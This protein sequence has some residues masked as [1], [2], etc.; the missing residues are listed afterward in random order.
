MVLNFFNDIKSNVKRESIQHRIVHKDGSVRWL[1]NS[2]SVRKDDNG[3]ISRMDGFIIDITEGRLAE[4][5]LKIYATT[6]VMT[7]LLNRRAGFIILENKLNYCRKNRISLSISFIDLNNLKKVND[8]FGHTE[9][10]RMIIKTAQ[11]IKQNIRDS[12]VAC[13]IGGDEFLLILPDCNIEAAEKIM[14]RVNSTL[15]DYNLKKLKEYK[16]SLSYGLEEYNEINN[17]AAEELVNK[18][19][20]RM[21]MSKRRY[22]EEMR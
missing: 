9:G 7:G 12:D 22:K 8:H 21:Y 1:L 4:E 15:D 20:E 2:C 19:D 13:R 14:C 10:N 11:V 3:N 17:L 5:Q 6:D 18:A 16:I